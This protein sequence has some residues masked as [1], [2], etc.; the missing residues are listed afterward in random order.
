MWFVLLQLWGSPGTCLTSFCLPWGLT[1][2]FLGCSGRNSSP[3]CSWWLT[4]L[5]LFVATINC[6]PGGL[7]LGQL[8]CLFGDLL[9]LLSM[10]LLFTYITILS[11]PL[12]PTLLSFLHLNICY[13]FYS[14]SCAYFFIYFDIFHSVSAFIFPVLHSSHPSTSF[15][16]CIVFQFISTLHWFLVSTITFYSILTT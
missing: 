14:V 5:L 15:S 11:I 16:Y 8:H 6:L 7:L 2:Y 12:N 9:A 4:Y 10:T 1:L 3:W 13:P